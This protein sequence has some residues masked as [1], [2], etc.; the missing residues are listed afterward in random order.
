MGELF[1]VEGREGYLA[2]R[3]DKECARETLQVKLGLL[4]AV[5]V[6]G[7]RQPLDCFSAS[8]GVPGPGSTEMA[9]CWE[10]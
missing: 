4:S 8:Q 7:L 2:W 3:R 1:S 9:V 6:E 5:S 10:D